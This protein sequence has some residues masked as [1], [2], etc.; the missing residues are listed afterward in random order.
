[1][2]TVVEYSGHSIISIHISV[3]K[4]V[5]NYRNNLGA[6]PCGREQLS[7]LTPVTAAAQ[8]PGSVFIQTPHH[9]HQ[10][11]GISTNYRR[12]SGSN[13]CLGQCCSCCRTHDGRRVFYQTASSKRAVV[14]RCPSQSFW[15][16]SLSLHVPVYE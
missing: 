7:P 1:V 13:L 2:R 3:N 6:D 5:R 15:S 12:Y 10:P 16:V 8:Q 9:H 4:P 14:I 11:R